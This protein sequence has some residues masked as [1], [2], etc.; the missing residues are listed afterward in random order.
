M[1]HFAEMLHIPP[2]EL[3]GLRMKDFAKLVLFVEQQIQHRQQ[4]QQRNQGG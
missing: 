1:G 2:R 4:Q 3:D